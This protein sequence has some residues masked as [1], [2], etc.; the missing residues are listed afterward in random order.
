MKPAVGDVVVLRGLRENQHNP[1][2]VAIPPR[3]AVVVELLK[4]GRL[5]VKLHMGTGGAW[6]SSRRWAM[7][8][9]IVTLANV[10]RLATERETVV[11]H[12][13]IGGGARTLTREE[14]AALYPTKAVA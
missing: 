1:D 10:V 14:I 5:A 11:G 2:S 4:R 13:N 7:R 3:I 12:P 6:R 8:A 9:R